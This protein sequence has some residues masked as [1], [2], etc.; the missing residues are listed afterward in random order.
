MRT[1]NIATTPS[2]LH[3]LLHLLENIDGQFDVLRVCLNGF[4]VVPE[5]LT[6]N[7][8]LE[9]YIPDADL[10]DHGRFVWLADA[11]DELYFTLADDFIFPADFADR[12]EAL[13]I[14][15]AIVSC[16]GLSFEPWPDEVAFISP[17]AYLDAS[18]YAYV[19]DTRCM[20]ICTS[21]FHPD[22]VG[23]GATVSADILLAHAAAQDEV[24]TLIAAHTDKW[25]TTR[26]PEPER[27]TILSDL[28]RASCDRIIGIWAK[29]GGLTD[30]LT[31]V[32]YTVI[33]GD[34]DKLRQPEHITPGWHY[35]YISDKKTVKRGNGIW[36]QYAMEDDENI[37]VDSPVLTQRFHK[38]LRMPGSDN[39]RTIYVDGN[40]TITGDLD[41]M[42]Y[43]SGHQAS[44]VTARKHPSRNCVYDEAKAIID[45]QLADAA[46]VNRWIYRMHAIGRKPNAGL[47]ETGVL[48]VDH[49]YGQA[50]YYPVDQAMRL[51]GALVREF[52]H[53]DQLT[54]DF[55][56][57]TFGVRNSVDAELFDPYVKWTPHTQQRVPVATTEADVEV[58]ED[59][60]DASPAEVSP[61]RLGILC[62]CDASTVHLAPLFAMTALHHNPGAH[63]TVLMPI[64]VEA[65][66]AYSVMLR[67]GVCYDA[68]RHPWLVPNLHCNQLAAQ[69]LTMPMTKTDLLYI[70]PITD[71]IVTDL[72]AT[73]LPLL[74]AN[75]VDFINTIPEGYTRM[76]VRHFTRF[77]ALHPNNYNQRS[78]VD[79][80]WHPQ[81]LLHRI[82]SDMTKKA[83]KSI[84]AP[85]VHLD[86]TAKEPSHEGRLLQTWQDYKASEDFYS[87][88]EFIEMAAVE[89]MEHSGLITVE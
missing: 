13:T 45:M 51:W 23:I 74:E 33:T 38:I 6:Y 67:H 32:C 89:D 8:K 82:V 69:W 40:M 55:A 68:I 52:C 47:S 31:K 60:A 19:G 9:C 87:L 70:C 64:D 58:A 7:P 10:G 25:I 26:E 88:M 39:E 34:Y 11:K 62:Q 77:D 41:R 20:V 80:F 79:R 76:G 42:V 49:N 65:P 43:A 72:K 86:I 71:M 81:L 12:M 16:G 28:E 53:R 24:S 59:V 30:N 1:A 66:D 22:I 50:E 54:F 17:I 46:L 85:V 36:M 44:K 27:S 35:S 14:D 15:A 5:E 48:I 18:H 3:L 84:A 56:M 29:N 63:V 61:L 83:I 37:V 57:E 4:T 75:D 2:R 78:D 21:V 73:M